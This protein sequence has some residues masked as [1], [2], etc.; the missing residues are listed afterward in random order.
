[1]SQ[2][3]QPVTERRAVTAPAAAQLRR[4]RRRFCKKFAKGSEAREKASPNKNGRKSGNKYRKQ[5]QT[6]TKVRATAEARLHP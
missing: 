4:Q 2:S 3:A 6:A 5:S 1:M